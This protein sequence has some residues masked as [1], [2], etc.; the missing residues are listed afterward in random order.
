M[1]AELPDHAQGTLPVLTAMLLALVGYPAIAQPAPVPEAAS[2]PI[3][4]AVESMPDIGID[5]PDLGADDTPI[6]APAIPDGT[7][8]APAPIQDAA[9]IGLGEQAMQEAERIARIDPAQP[10][11]YSV[12]VTGLEKIKD[13]LFFSRFDLLSELRQGEGDEAN[14]AQITRRARADS[15]LLERLLRTRGYYDPQASFRLN[16]GSE[17]NQRLRVEME[18][19]PGPLYLLD[20]VTVKGLNEA[21][22]REKDIRALFVVEPGDAADT[23][24]ILGGVE[25]LRTGLGEGGY[26]FARVAEPSLTVDHDKRSAALDLMIE[27]GGYRRIGRITVNADAPFDAEH[28]FTIARFKTGHQYRASRVADLDRALIAT[29]LVSTARI[30]TS[31]TRDPEAVDLDITLTKA[32]PRTIAGELGYGT[33]E[34]ARVEVSWQH[35]NLFPPEGALTVRGVLGTDEQSVSAQ[36]RRN[37]FKGRDRTLTAQI[38]FS[39]LNQAAYDARIIGFSASLERLTTLVFQKKFTW[40]L[41]TELLLSDER[42]DY[43]NPPQP[44]RRNFVIAALSAGATYDRS[45]NLLDPKKGFRISGRI[46]PEISLQGGTFGYGRAQVDGSAYLPLSE[47]ITIAGRA[48]LGTIIGASADRIAPTRRYY[49]GGGGS[50]RGYSY[51]AIGPRDLNND[52]LGGRSLAEISIEARLRF[53]SENQFGIVPFVDA[54]TISSDAFPAFRDMRMGAGLGLRYYSSFGPIRVDVG[55]PINPQASDPPIGV[56]VSLGQAF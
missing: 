31:G 25:A 4:P 29:G 47:R 36:F 35:R 17:G 22:R 52:P 20:R 21:D 37:N 53:G 16:P 43:G 46:A 32:P 26:P 54:G 40:V 14:L 2:P 55:T 1:H 23:D 8:T 28:I 42:D 38:S 9:S 33:G 10:L 44:R 6:A 39:K 13:R 34:G 56:Y 12:V 50:V 30:E 11:R 45:D 49:S 5:W 3:Q 41:G 19:L 15:D 27:T 51:Q 24:M 48:R 18:S 7:A